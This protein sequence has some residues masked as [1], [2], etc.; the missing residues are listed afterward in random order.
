[1]RYHIK[2]LLISTLLFLPI[3]VYAE[4]LS[5]TCE[6]LSISNTSCQNL[7]SADCRAMLEKCANY[8]DQQ[9]LQISE[10]ITKTK[11]QKNTLQAQITALKKK[12]TGLEYQINQG[13]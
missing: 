7:S 6:K 11:Q 13:T 8:Y 2:T 4:D 3:F 12:I 10:D 5:A 1:M 9:S